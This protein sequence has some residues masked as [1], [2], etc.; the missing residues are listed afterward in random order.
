MLD[1][2]GADKRAQ[3]E[4]VKLLLRMIGAV[5]SD[6]VKPPDVGDNEFVNMKIEMFETP[7]GPPEEDGEVVEEPGTINE[8]PVNRRVITL[9]PDGIPSTLTA[10][11]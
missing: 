7:T 5:E 3:P 1:P 10:L 6:L 8:A 11:Q 4:V 2:K 9:V